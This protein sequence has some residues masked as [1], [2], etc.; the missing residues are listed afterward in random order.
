LKLDKPFKI[1]A[2]DR[3]GLYVHSQLDSDEGTSFSLCHPACLRLS[4]S[5]SL[6]IPPPP[7]L[8]IFVSWSVLLCPLATRFTQNMFLSLVVKGVR[9][10]TI[11][12]FLPSCHAPRIKGIV[13]DNSSQRSST[14]GAEHGTI[15]IHSGMAHLNPTPFLSESPWGENGWGR[16][17]PGWRNG[18][19]F[20]GKVN[21]GVRWLLW[22]PVVN[23]RFPKVFQH[24]AYNFITSGYRSSTVV[25][26]LPQE[27]VLFILNFCDWDHFGTDPVVE[28]EEEEEPE[29]HPVGGSAFR[30]FLAQIA[31]QLGGQI[32]F[33]DNPDLFRYMAM[34]YF[35]QQA[36][37]ADSDDEDEDD[38]DDEDEDE[39]DE[40]DKDDENNEADEDGEDGEDSGNGEVDGNDYEPAVKEGDGGGAAEPA[41]TCD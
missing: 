36:G 17:S 3:H 21:Y 1:A 14:P 28:E 10:F 9:H 24:V 25:A 12:S 13:Y 4:F 23:G 30:S 34:Q 39:D 35:D 32:A 33:E 7:V 20:V 19:E 15:L 26:A 29:P 27:L 18:R 22:D 31:P 11:R 5:L 16:S 2:G 37:G 38:E 40:D 8:L 41:E 6:S